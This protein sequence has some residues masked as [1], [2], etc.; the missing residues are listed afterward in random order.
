M[1]RPARGEHEPYYAGYIGLVPGRDGGDGRDGVRGGHEGDIVQILARQLEETSR[2]FSQ[3]DEA[4]S[5]RRYAPGKWSIKQVVGHVVDVERVFATRG[6]VMARGDA[7]PMPGLEQDQWVQAADFDER[8]FAS[9]V[10]EYR[11][12]R[13]S[14]VALFGSW[15]DGQSLRVGRASGCSFTARCWPWIIAGHELHHVRVLRERYL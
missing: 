15:T 2:F 6:L 3:I 1:E 8:S 4:R 13:A 5:S 11:L 12:V 7:A 10:E 14:N 9:L